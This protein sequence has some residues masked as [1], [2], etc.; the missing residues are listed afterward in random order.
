MRSYAA[1][2]G[3][4]EVRFHGF[5][6]DGQG[7]CGFLEGGTRPHVGGVA[8]AIP[9][10]RSDGQGITCDVSQLCLPGHKDVLAA[11]EAA[12]TIALATGQN[13]VVTA[14]MHIDDAD[15]SQI[16]ALMDNAM[17]AIGLFLGDL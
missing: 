13:T 10:P 17:R 2:E 5:Q 8:S 9:R 14:G 6:T 1:G 15:E 11:A 16:K 4:F 12:R 3:P 7:I